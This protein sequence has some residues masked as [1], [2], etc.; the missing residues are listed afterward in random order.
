[1]SNKIL[2]KKLHWKRQNYRDGKQIILLLGFGGRIW[3]DYRSQ[4]DSVAEGIVLHS[5]V[6]V[7]PVS[8]GI[9]TQNYIPQDV[10]F[11]L[12]K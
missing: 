3:F 10:N 7:T 6:M 9:R 1:M 11:T 12:C 5:V 8:A 4:R 2:I